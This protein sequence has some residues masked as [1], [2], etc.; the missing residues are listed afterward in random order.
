MINDRPHR[1]ISKSYFDNNNDSKVGLLFSDL[2]FTGEQI[3]I[4]PEQGKLNVLFRVSKDLEV[5]EDYRKWKN[6]LRVMDIK[7]SVG[8]NLFVSGRL[9]KVWGGKRM[10]DWSLKIRKISNGY[11]CE[12]VEHVAEDKYEVKETVFQ[13][14]DYDKEDGFENRH[15]VA[16]LLYYVADYFGEEGS[17]HDDYRVRVNV[18]NQKEEE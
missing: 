13:F 12:H 8:L 14:N 4:K 18:V 10:N 9:L 1:L 2:M 5:L 7:L 6:I 3:L 17:K 15:K 11:V 16:E